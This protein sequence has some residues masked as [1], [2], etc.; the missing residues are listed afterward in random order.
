MPHG[1][2]PLPRPATHFVRPGGTGVPP[3][4]APRRD[5]MDR[6]EERLK[7]AAQALRTLVEI[8]AMDIQP[9]V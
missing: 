1:P 2:G 3:T 4:R 6:L 9:E 5:K 8:Q 7:T